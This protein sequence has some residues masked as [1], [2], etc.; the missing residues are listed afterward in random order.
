MPKRSEG[1]RG[2]G[3]GGWRNIFRP[4]A[5]LLLLKTDMR[6]TTPK[7]HLYK[8]TINVPY[9]LISGLFKALVPHDVILKGVVYMLE[10]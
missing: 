3:E 4:G 6:R 2:G 10:H 1:R 8:R 7:T 5:E 9:F